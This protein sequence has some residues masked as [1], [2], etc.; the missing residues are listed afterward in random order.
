[1]IRA[2]AQAPPPI[3]VPM[4]P[5]ATLVV[6][7]EGR[8]ADAWFGPS[9]PIAA[10]AAAGCDIFATLDVDDT[11]PDAARV[12]VLLASACGAIAAA[13]P[14]LAA[15]APPTL[16]RRDGSV[17]G[18]MWSPI[19]PG[20]TIEGLALFVAAGASAITLAAPPEDPVETNRICV[21]ALGLLDECDACIRHLH[22]DPAARHLVHHMFRA[23]HTI[24][25]S[26]RGTSLRTISDLAHGIEERLDLLRTSDDPAGSTSIAGLEADLRKLRGAVVTS[27]PRG[28]VDDAMTEMSAD[29]RHALSDLRASLARLRRD[30]R[31][32]IDL[33]ARAVHRISDAADRAKFRA[34]GIQCTGARNAIAMIA[35][36]ESP[37]D[38]SLLGE[39]AALEQHVELY[40]NVYREVAASDAGPS[41][42][43]TLASLLD[44]P[45]D[46]SGSFDGL[47]GVMSGAGVPSLIAAFVAED[48]FAMRRA[49][50]VLVDASAMFEPARPRDDASLR[51]ERAQRDLL[52]AI[53]GLREVPPANLADMRAIVQRLVWTQLATIGRRLPRMARSLS[54][55][56]GKNVAVEI[57]LGDLLVAPEIGRVIGEILVHAL[58]NAADHGIESPAERLEAGKSEKG[59][60]SITATPC[61]ERVTVTVRDD[62]RG[63]AIEKVRRIAVERGLIEATAAAQLSPNEVVELLFMPG[64]S[65]A[66]TVTAVSG[67][68]VGMDVIKSLA[69]AHGGSV[70]VTSSPGAGTL[71]VLDLPL[72]PP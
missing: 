51:F 38:R 67:R 59:T 35:D 13:W 14:V 7:A 9:S 25:G 68:G 53:D 30:D 47:V 33:A 42:L 23:V 58:R 22:A 61:G 4:F 52:A 2:A 60:I 1:M 41:V 8:I 62:G 16:V 26:T 27:R 50:A 43:V 32:A 19:A 45:D 64:F 54:A 70:D 39:L 12:Q 44:A 71:L 34:L 20:P 63:I 57:D 18:V 3:P 11:T 29:C 66:T 28:E 24:K 15:D 6:D 46:V 49:L 56:L 69:E 72:A 40:A 37:I 21:D 65:T 31:G 10:V 5:G 48:P 17:L 36:S 55:E